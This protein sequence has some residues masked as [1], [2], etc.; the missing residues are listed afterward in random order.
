M[1]SPLCGHS[2][3]RSLSFCKERLLFCCFFMQAEK[4][5]QRQLARFRQS[6]K[7]AERAQLVDMRL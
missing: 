5:E 7:R 1:I 6:R 3:K 2:I 4:S